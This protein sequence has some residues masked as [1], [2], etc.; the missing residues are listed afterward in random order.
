MRTLALVVLLAVLVVAGCS[1]EKKTTEQYGKTLTGAIPESKRAATAVNVDAIRTALQEYQ[2][3]HGRFPDRLED[4]PLVQN[5]RLDVSRLSYN[6]ET[7][8]VEVKP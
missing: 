3:E 1:E 7:G 4:L 6:K 5:Q 8:T 2:L